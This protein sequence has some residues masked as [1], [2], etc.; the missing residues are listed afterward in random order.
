MEKL[1]V[2]YRTWYKA[3]PPKRI[4]LKVPGWAGDSHG[5]SDGDKPQPWHCT[6]FVDGSTYGLELLYP[7]ES[8][9]CVRRENGVVIFDGDFT[10]EAPWASEQEGQ[11][12]PPFSSFAPGH[13]GFTSSL[14]LMPPEGYCMRVEPHPRFFTDETGTVPI[15]VPGHIQRWW[16]RIFFVAF[17]SPSEGQEH[18]FRYNEPYAQILIVPEKVTYDLQEMSNEEKT[19]RSVREQTIANNAQ[20][21][22][23]N[24]WNDHVDHKFD[25]KYKQ[26]KSAYQKKGDQGV[27]DAL[28]TATKKEVDNRRNATHIKKRFFK[29]IRKSK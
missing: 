2:K 23:K 15:A 12:P 18:I 21:I 10:G 4:K 14:D 27:E 25:D 13:Y 3:I 5:H 29:N 8:E 16:S 26:L 22:A 17:K 19:K 7:F 20:Y 24:I 1:E 28:K 11:A 9:C 6:P